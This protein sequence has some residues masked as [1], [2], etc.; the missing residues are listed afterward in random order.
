MADGPAEDRRLSRLFD[1]F[2]G[3]EDTDFTLAKMLDEKK[4]QNRVA[5]AAFCSYLQLPEKET[6]PSVLG[7]TVTHI[8]LFDSDLARRVTD[9]TTIDL[10]ASSP[11]NLCPSTSRS[12]PPVDRLPSAAQDVALRPDARLDTA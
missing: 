2:A 8:R 7:T 9:T 3:E 5:R 4:I 10:D 1:L 11:A 6:R 12:A